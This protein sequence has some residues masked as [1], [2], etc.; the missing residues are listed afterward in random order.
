V[1]ESRGRLCVIESLLHG[2]LF[3]MIPYP[4]IESQSV[5]RVRS[6]SPRTA[7]DHFE[8]SSVASVRASTHLTNDL[9]PRFLNVSRVREIEGVPGPSRDLSQV[10]V[11]NLVAE[12]HPIKHPRDPIGPNL[13][14]VQSKFHLLTKPEQQK[15]KTPAFLDHLA[16]GQIGAESRRVLPWK[17]LHRFNGLPRAHSGTRALGGNEHRH[18]LSPLGDDDS[19]SLGRSL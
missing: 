15:S 16:N 18:G 8:A 2:A 14:A 3:T 12:R 7:N 19:L 13:F 10:R 17:S 1:L 4:G 5:G 6:H 9:V 11:C